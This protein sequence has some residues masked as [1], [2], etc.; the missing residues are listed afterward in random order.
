ME[1][2]IIDVKDMENFF[3]SALVKLGYAPTDTECEDLADIC[4]DYL[5]EVGLI[6]Y[7]EED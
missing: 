4:L 2:K 7:I 5:L 1:I 3:W 6:D